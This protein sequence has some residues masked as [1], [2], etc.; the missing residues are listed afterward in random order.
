M[1]KNISI[2]LIFV[3]VSAL[4]CGCAAEKESPDKN[5]VN[6]A[7]NSESNIGDLDSV[8]EVYSGGDC[9]A[10]LANGN[11]LYISAENSNEVIKYK[12]GNEEAR[13][14]PGEGMH[15]NLC[16]SD[17]FL[18]STSYTDKGLFLNAF[19]IAGNE[20]KSFELDHS[21][22]SV[23]SMCAVGTYVYAVTSD[24]GNYRKY[25]VEKFDED[26][27]YSNYGEAVYKINTSD[28]STEKMDIP[29][30]VCLSEKANGI[31]V[32]Y[33]YDS[34]G[35]Y[36]FTEYN[37]EK[38]TFSERKYNNNFKYI[39]SFATDGDTI[40]FSDLNNAKVSS[41]G[42]SDGIARSD[43]AFNIMAKSGNDVQFSD[44][45][46]YALD[47]M[48]GNVFKAPAVSAPKNKAPI[49][50]C[51]SELFKS[52]LPTCGHTLKNEHVS[53]EEF[54]LKVLAND[55]DYDICMMRTGQSFSIEL[56]NKGA[57]YSLND[58][59]Y[60]K[61]YTDALFPGLKK[62]ATDENGDI[63]MLPVSAEV[64]YI[65][66]NDEMCSKYGIDIKSMTC[67]DIY[68]A[69]KKLYPDE[70][71]RESFAIRGL[72]SANCWI[73][74]Y[75]SLMLSKGNEINY[76]SDTF[77]DICG[78]LTEYPI[79]SDFMQ[80][81]LKNTYDRYDH[82][83]FI[84][85]VETNLPDLRN[86][87]LYDLNVAGF[88]LICEGA[89]QT[90]DCQYIC[91]NASSDNLEGTLEYISSYC[92]YMLESKNTFIFADKSS[93]TDIDKP[94]ISGL[95]EVYSDADVVFRLPR[96]VFEEDYI[97]FLYEDMSA[98][99]FIKEINRKV[100]TYLNE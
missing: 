38:N 25:D 59:P 51:I 92:K 26:D 44:G 7:S 97:K 5:N 14:S 72:V 56:R 42:I 53:D 61:E 52:D 2:I 100:N 73:E 17:N 62:T 95:Y 24:G 78:M 8:R 99:D 49:R 43:I 41:S 36:Y 39:F 45:Y 34:Q 70:G 90:A 76:D 88:P 40:F 57:F 18:Y 81:V 87:G 86:D 60:V 91:V 22:S 64:V 63:W 27:D 30:I 94:L 68:K 11:E 3:L 96:E 10:F 67:E 71:L 84:F 83:S 58:V 15:T 35:G 32:F 65:L 6:I 98:D 21:V 54:C 1:K 13:Y 66:Y 23:L 75:E 69:A 79:S 16:I 80:A 31:V 93:Y 46:C 33:A 4:I 55:S 77:R 28:G 82:D 48:T 85:S 29:N 89:K 37:C 47:F 12:D 74:Q 20:T 50:A 9:A 19:N